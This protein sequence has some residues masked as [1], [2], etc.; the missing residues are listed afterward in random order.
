M[1]ATTVTSATTFLSPARQLHAGVWAQK[2]NY[3]YNGVTLSASD[4]IFLGYIPQGAI[5]LDG[6]AW[7]GDGA[8]G[9][10]FKFGVQGSEA[11]FAG[12]TTISV[13]GV[14][15]F[16]VSSV[17][18]AFSLSSDAQGNLQIVVTATKVA[19]TSTITGCVNLTLLLYMPPA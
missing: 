15:R 7:G 12:T 10:T 14:A 13:S 9:T 5:V 6:Q 19:G 16:G 2:F 1:A 3:K 11:A 4:V 17:P 18:K 8:T